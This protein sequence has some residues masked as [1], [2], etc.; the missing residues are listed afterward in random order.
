[1]SNGEIHKEIFK[2]SI[3]SLIFAFASLININVIVPPYIA[4]LGGNICIVGIIYSLMAIAKTF[5]S[6]LSGFIRDKFGGKFA[7]ILSMGVMIF[8][9]LV[10]FIA[11]NITILTIGLIFY[12]FAKGM[13]V[14]AL[15]STTATIAIYGEVGELLEVSFDDMMGGVKPL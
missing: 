2:L 3:I 5:S 11:N 8:S 1:M 9:F 15:F 4:R 13:E 6:M 10:L 12:G 14:P 7:L